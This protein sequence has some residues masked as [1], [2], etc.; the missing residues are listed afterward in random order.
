METLIQD[1][2]YGLR[3]LRRNPGFGITVVLIL[4]IG[5]G[6]NSAVFSVVDSILLKPLPYAN[7]DRLVMLRDTGDQDTKT[8]LSYPEF[9]AWREHKDIFESVGA[10]FPGSAD[11]TSPGDPQQFDVVHVSTELLPMLGIQLRKGRTFTAQE[12]LAEGAPAAIISDSFWHN[13]L[14]DDPNVL[15]SALT[16]NSKTYTVVGILPPDFHFAND[17][18]LVLPLRLNADLAP[19][20]YNFLR[21]IGK[22]HE[23]ATIQRVRSAALTAIKSVNDAASSTDGTSI[24]VVTLQEFLIGDSRPLLLALLGTVAFV[25]LIACANTANLLL[26]RAASREKEIAIRMSLGSGRIRLVR[27]LLTESLLLSVIGGLVGL[28]FARWGLGLLVSLLGDKLP[29]STE[30][31]LDA[32][33]FQFT[34]LISLVTG[35]LFGLAPAMQAGKLNLVDRLKLGGRLS[36]GLTQAQIVRNGLIVVE[37]AF[38][39]VLLAGTGLLL[40]SF[41][42]LANVDKGFDPDHV[43]TMHVAVNSN[44]YPDPKREITYLEQIVQNTKNLPGVESVG[45]VSN[46]PFS[47]NAISGDF[48]IQGVAFDPN[49]LSNASKEF[50]VG[51]YFRAMHLP[52]IKGRF[53]NESDTAESRSVVVVDQ[54]F[55]RQYFPNQEALGKRIDVGWGK[56]GWSEIVGV[57]GAA[58][59]FAMTSAPIPTIYSPME[60]KPD[61]LEFLAFDLAV[62]TRVNPEA[63]IQAVTNQIHQLDSTQVIS[64]VQTMDT[65]IDSKLASRRDPMWLFAC[66]SIAAVLLAGIGIYGVLS[67][68]VLQ[69]NSEIGTRM[70]LG[71]QRGDILKLVVGHALRLVTGGVVLGLAVSIAIAHLLKSLLFGVA[72]TDIPTFIGVSVLLAALALIACAV[73][74]MRA[75]RVDPLVVLRNE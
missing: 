44:K 52:L 19:A 59:E 37:I 70:A 38:S 69:R 73:P 68:Y 13:R 4:A 62:R 10:Y 65:L 54:A 14:H 20:R 15:G 40:R 74:A 11:L 27:Q 36:G 48:L 72:P 30:I 75:T 42:R 3:M 29:H 7:S 33:V 16:L 32:S 6:A 35:I 49:N 66:F 23:G 2:R 47:G 63:Q 25:L 60:Q 45:F 41:I 22:T 28:L 64:K 12:E 21:V 34:A 39:L 61:L 17:P 24:S 53:I 5:I 26:A 31:H 43:L 55:A 56:R 9:Q 46:L 67:Y 51:D 57:V 18:D 1:I 58:R 71:A 50:V 8:P